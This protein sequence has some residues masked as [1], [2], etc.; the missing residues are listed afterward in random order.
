MTW[1]SLIPE[2][3]FRIIS[4]AAVAL[5]V[6]FMR[7]WKNQ[8]STSMTSFRA[9]VVKLRDSLT[10]HSEDM[11]KSTKAV[12]GDM[13]KIERSILDL[14]KDLNGKVDLIVKESTNI[15]LQFDCLA[16]QF[17]NGIDSFDARYGRV[18]ALQGE[19]EELFGKVKVLDDEVKKAE[20]VGKGHREAFQKT[21]NILR[22]LRSDIDQIG[23]K[24]DI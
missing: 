5:A 17:R 6:Y 13:L 2:D 15:A 20:R 12:N 21:A 10:K 14:E 11:G 18:L 19:V 23:G 7:E 9:Q 4:I 24:N 1:A 16:S 22:K 3:P 8:I